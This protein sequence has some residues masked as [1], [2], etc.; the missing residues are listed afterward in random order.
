M[1]FHQMTPFILKYIARDQRSLDYHDS[2][3][4]K[5]VNFADLTFDTTELPV[6]SQDKHIHTHAES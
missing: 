5:L 6:P 3:C 4:C 2:C 1:C